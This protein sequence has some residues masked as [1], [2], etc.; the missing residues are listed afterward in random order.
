MCNILHMTVT[1]LRA[2]VAPRAGKS[3][4]MGSMLLKKEKISFEMVFYTFVF[5]FSQSSEIALES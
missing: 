4:K 2:D 1:S 5:R 3:L